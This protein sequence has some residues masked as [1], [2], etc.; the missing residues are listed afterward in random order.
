MAAESGAVFNY[1]SGATQ[2]L[3]HVF[4]RA[5]GTDI[6]ECRS[7]L[8]GETIRDA[9]QFSGVFFG[10]FFIPDMSLLIKICFCH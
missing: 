8:K 1:N 6:E 5:T 2:L 4:R 10:D 7:G 3:A 9:L